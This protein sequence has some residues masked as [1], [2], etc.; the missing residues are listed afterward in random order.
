MKSFK[1]GFIEFLISGTPESAICLFLILLG[2]LCIFAFFY[3]IALAV[4][5]M[6]N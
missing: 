4:I 1:N 6:R 3:M 5:D 2:G